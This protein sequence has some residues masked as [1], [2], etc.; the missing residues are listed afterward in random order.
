MGY[1]INSKEASQGG[2]KRK[3]LVIGL[4]ALMVLI[5]VF[6]GAFFLSRKSSV[7]DINYVIPNVPYIGINNH[8]GEKGVLIQG[9]TSEIAMILDYWNP[10]E[11]DFGQLN[12]QVKLHI[13]H[14]SRDSLTMQQAGAVI[15]ELGNYNVR[16]EHLEIGDLKKYI[17][18][19]ART[20]LFVFLPISSPDP[21][22]IP[23]SVATLVIGIKE[24]EKKI[25]LHDYWFGNN[26]EITYEDFNSR[27]GR[28]KPNFRNEYLVVQPTDFKSAMEDIKNRA[29]TAY[30][31]RTQVMSQI[32]LMM[33]EYLR[34][35]E[36][37]MESRSE[38]AVSYF[39]KVEGD[40]KF[41][42]FLPPYLKVLLYTQISQAFLN[43]N[44]FDKAISYQKKA[45]ELNHDLDKPFLDWP[46]YEMRY[47]EPGKYGM[48]SQP[49][50]VLGDIYFA[51]GKYADAKKAYLNALEIFPKHLILTEKYQAAQLKLSGK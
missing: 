40:Q 49:G 1:V 36:A 2:A 11:N 38:E 41:N 25:V 21:A 50:S 15:N 6:V 27:M 8:V 47:N 43:K 4:V 44:D 35:Y 32:T 34:G 3:Y 29:V 12:R 51:Q 20:P 46:G 19:E 9:S 22:S 10:R 7:G 17:N 28:K 16:N 31:K 45:D 37:L 42:E 18:P 13:D 24:D 33:G 48:N 26:F 39:S 23:Y 5:F 30:P 14:V